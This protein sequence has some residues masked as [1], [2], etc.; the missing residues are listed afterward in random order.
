MRL[1]NTYEDRD[2]AEVAFA[3]LSGEKRIASERDDTSTIYNLFGIPTWGNL[4]RIEMYSLKE[5][6]KLLRAKEN[7]DSNDKKRHSE[8]LQIINIASKNLNIKI[9]KHWL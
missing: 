7:W 6:E 2:D 3:M 5:F 9:P 4:Y 8:I 1:L